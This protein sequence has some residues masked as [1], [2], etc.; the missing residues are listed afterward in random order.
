MINVLIVEDDPMVA[1]LNKMYVETVAGFKVK[2]VAS[3]GE[4]A[5]EYLYNKNID[6][7]ILDIYMPKMDGL[8]LFKKMRADGILTDVILVTAAHEV[9]HIDSALKLGAID[10]LIKPFQYERLKASLENYLNRRLI[11]QQKDDFQQKDI[12][13]IT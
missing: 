6:L 8:S 1:E 11:L 13:K 10:Y 3:T 2:G 5:L 7:V 4:K 12:D 9:E